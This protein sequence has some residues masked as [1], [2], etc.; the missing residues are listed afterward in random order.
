[1]LQAIFNDGCVAEPEVR[2]F[3]GRIAAL[4]A[5]MSPSRADQP[6]RDVVRAALGRE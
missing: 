3:L 5:V 6:V 2:Q 1:V 4:L